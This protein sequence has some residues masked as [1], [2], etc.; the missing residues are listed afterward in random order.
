[1]RAPPITQVVVNST[2]ATALL[3]ASIREAGHVAI[4]IVAPH[5][6]YVIGHLQT[7]LIQLQHLFVRH[8]HLHLLLGGTNV[9]AQKL[10]LVVYYLLQAV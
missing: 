2:T 1:M 4:V 9:L 6:G 7:L 10:L 5:K 3:L 8:K